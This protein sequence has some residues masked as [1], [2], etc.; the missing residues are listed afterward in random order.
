MALIKITDVSRTY[1]SGENETKALEGVSLVIERGEFVAVVGPSGS[2]KSTLMHILGFL[3]RPTEGNYL[4]DGVDMTLMDDNE[5][6]RLRRDQ[7]GFVFQQ[8]NLLPRHTAA[9]NV[10]LPMVYNRVAEPQRL[11]KA[12]GLLKQVGLADRAEHT[13]AELSGGQMQRVAIARALANDP[14]VILAD[15]PTGNLDSASGKQVLDQLRKLHRAGK[16]IIIVTHDPGIAA[17]AGRTVTVLDGRLESDSGPPK[18]ARPAKRKAVKKS[19]SKTK[20][21]KK[22]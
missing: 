2:G 20:K 16:T 4:F 14:E 5:L 13:P 21:A 12:A 19:A 3:D 22:S 15:E 11:Q 8:I 6:A 17:A 18:K 7:I 10:A 9:E 1:G